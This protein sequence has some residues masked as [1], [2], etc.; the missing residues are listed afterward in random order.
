MKFQN[1]REL[2]V[3]VTTAW[4]ALNDDAI[5]HRCIPGCESLQRAEPDVLKAVVVLAIGPV[6]ARFNGT[7]RFEDIQPLKGY[8]M[9]FEGNGGIAGF[10]KG[11]AEVQLAEN[12]DGTT[13]LA[14]VAEAQIGGKIAQLGSRL[15]DAASQK[16]TGQFF[17][18]FEQELSNA[19]AV[20]AAAPLNASD[21]A[22]PWLRSC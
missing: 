13:K 20:E 10:S 15:I 1:E 21:E 8:R 4:A 22:G 9:V 2:P 16:I 3:S 14:Y 18:R 11:T 7:V 19:C 12:A 17:A 6:K 5:L